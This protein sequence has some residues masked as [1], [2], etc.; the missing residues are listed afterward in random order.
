MVA[1][2]GG[3]QQKAKQWTGTAV[4]PERAWSNHL[5]INMTPGDKVLH[6]FDDCQA[7]PADP[8]A[9]PGAKHSLKYK[10]ELRTKVKRGNVWTA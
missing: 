2:E 5:S 4:E 3:N 1:C 9:L 7:Q 10:S 8:S 6:Y